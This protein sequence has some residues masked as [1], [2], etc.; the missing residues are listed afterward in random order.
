[1]RIQRVLAAFVC[2]VLFL[3]CGLLYADSVQYEL[4]FDITWSADTHPGAFPSNAH[5][6]RLVGHTHNENYR[7]W[8]PGELSS[9]GTQRIAELG[10]TTAA[11]TEMRN[12]QSAGD[13]GVIF[14]AGGLGRV[15]ASRTHVFE[16]NL[17]FPMVS[18]ASMIAPSPDWFVGGSGVVLHDGEK[19][20]SEI[21]FDMIP[22]DAGTDSGT[23]FTSPNQATNPHTVIH[24]LVNPLDADNSIGRFTLRLVSTPGDFDRDGTLGPSDVDMLCDAWGQEHADINLTGAPIV[25]EKDLTYLVET[26]AGTRAGDTDLN[27]AVEFEDFVALVN[28]YRQ[29]GTWG[30]GDFNCSGHTDFFD[31]LT[32]SGNFGFPPNASTGAA[33]A[34]EATAAAV[35][36]P[37][38]AMVM[39]VGIGLLVKRQR[40]REV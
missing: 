8:T 37:S 3:P 32:L 29:D 2:G 30:T 16:A 40:R 39:L 15:P 21:A 13:A 6:S 12:A 31:F 33:P 36:E 7:L 27:G 22:W 38:A 18:F 10:S 23:D 14:D 17:S 11:N 9:L 20:L 26:L 25:D 24:E 35:P 34:G 5:F 1:M 28:G 19:W 4:L